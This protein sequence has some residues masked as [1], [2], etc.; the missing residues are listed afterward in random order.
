MAY[1]LGQAYIQIMPSAEGISGKITEALGGEAESAG[2]TVGKK[3]AASIKT[4]IVAAGIGK[5]IK[6]AVSE[7]AALEQSIG[8]IE[9]LFGAG[10]QSLQ[11]YAKSVGKTAEEARA[12]YSS[13]IKAQNTM[14]EYA[15][16]AYKNAGLSANSYMETAT[17]FAAALVSSTGGDTKAAA[18]AANTAIMDMSDN[19]NKM[20]SSMES[21]QNAYQGFAK[22]NYT[23]LDNLKLG[24]GGTKQ[25]MERL[26]ADAQEITGIEYNLDNLN[27]VYAAIHV[28]QD[29]LGITGTTAREAA[30]TFQGSYASMKAAAQNLLGNMAL[31]KDIE[32][33]LTALGD[34]VKVFLVDNLLPMIGK[35]FQ[36]LP[37]VVASA[38]NGLPGLIIKVMEQVGPLAQNIL[39]LLPSILQNLMN[40]L[41]GIL[42]TLTTTILPQLFQA[43]LSVL[44]QLGQMLATQIPIFFQEILPLLLSLSELLLENSGQLVEA[45]IE[46]ILAIVNGLMEALPTLIE[47]VPQIITN[48]C[49]IIN[50]NMPKII[51]A[52]IAIIIALGEGLINALPTLLANMGNILQAIISAV[53]AI[54]WINVGSTILK[55]I[56]NG[57]KALAKSPIE[58]IKDI[59]KNIIDTF[60]NGFSWSDLGS[61]VIDGLKNGISKGAKAVANAIKN[62]AKNALDGV[63]SFLGIHSPSRVFRDEVGKMIDLGWAEGVTDN[64]NPVKAAMD[65]ISGITTEPLQS[66]IETSLVKKTSFTG[67]DSSQT[68]MD[69]F[70]DKLI[71]KW[72]D[73]DI[74][75]PVYLGRDKFDEAVVKAMTIA[76]YRSGGR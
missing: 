37:K 15:D 66:K 54:N 58:I 55:G 21:I 67:E 44:Q 61:A 3:I 20:G 65:E 48:I 12:E 29:E 1:E 26:L 13:L 47:Y 46:M 76:D 56:A 72:P 34:T 64:L 24:Y 42:S 68:S 27:D 70:I 16:E 63:L 5:V 57:I 43:V 6:S 19:A 71:A 74:V 10:G 60:K 52:A 23:M 62:V 14:F 17:G 4:A 45:G 11:E 35:I 40:G 7:G 18:E 49:N 75:I 51:A 39:S 41:P 8:G 25:E 33:S 36:A 22:Q 2:S 53:S 30:S 31:G 59:G 69:E 28:I 32:P 9:T 38:I 50:E 73:N